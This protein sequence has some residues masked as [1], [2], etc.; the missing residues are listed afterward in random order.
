VGEIN[1]ET[2]KDMIANNVTCIPLYIYRRSL[3]I[4]NTIFFPVKTRYEDILIDPLI[5]LYAQKIASV[6]MPLYNYFIRSG[7]TV[8]EIN[9]TKYEDKIQ[10]SKLIIEEYKKRNFYEKYKNEVD[11][12]YFR[13]GY[14][15]SSI[16]YILN[17][18]S[19]DKQVIKNIKNQLLEI[20]PDY[21]KNVYYKNNRSFALIDFVLSSNSGILLWF[22][23]MGLKI[24][25]FS[26]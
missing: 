25:K 1:E 12:L 18:S 3:F 24:M 19:P 6:K 9:T 15:H 21:K 10:V 14:I 8:T 13:K 22:L 23:K 26:I 7:S 2:R 17:S 20:S 5:L 11:Y 16:N 4:N